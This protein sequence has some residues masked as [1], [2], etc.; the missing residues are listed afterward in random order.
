MSFFNLLLLVILGTT[1]AIR[2]DIIDDGIGLPGGLRRPVARVITV[3]S[4]TTSPMT[5]PGPC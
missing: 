2:L 3:D 1:P 5:L 4:T